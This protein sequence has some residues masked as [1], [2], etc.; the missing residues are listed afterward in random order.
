M[1][2]V[3]GL[4]IG[5][6]TIDVCMRCQDKNHFSKVDNTLQG[7][8]SLLNI[9]A[10]LQIEMVVCEPTGGYEIK[11]CRELVKAGYKVHR[12][13]TYAFS[14]FAK[15]ISLSKTDREDS[16][17]LAFYGALMKP[18]ATYV[19]KQIQ[20]KLKSYQSYRESLVARVSDL[21]RS[22]DKVSYDLVKAGLE[23]Q[24]HLLTQEIKLIEQ[25]CQSLIEEA[26]DFKSKLY[27]LTSIPG[28]GV[29]LALKLLAYLP[30]LGCQRWSL[31]QLSSLV[32][33]APYARESGQKYGKRFTRSGRRIP[34]DA[35]YMAVLTGRK[36][37]ASIDAL[38]E[39][40]AAQGKAKKVAMVAAMRKLLALAH[41][42][43]KRMQ[44]FQ[45]TP[46]KR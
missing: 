20:E 2:T 7:H 33:V 1:S 26:S 46:L 34:R 8:Q 10:C 13:N 14:Q 28:I 3:V 44:T 39:R 29:C 16:A 25:A 21:K 4:D 42:L 24:I 9:L 12:V 18:T 43:L 17:K 6:R 15:S 11:V 5:K 22:L 31:N 32:G 19:D 37:I 41:S 40:I 45:E 38:Y 27:I 23:R 35:L 30:E 36:K